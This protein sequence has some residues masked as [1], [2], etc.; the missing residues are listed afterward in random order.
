M[1]DTTCDNIQ[2]LNKKE[3]VHIYG[4]RLP[5]WF[6]ENKTVFVTFRLADSLPQEKTGRVKEDGEG[7]SNQEMDGD[8]RQKVRQAAS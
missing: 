1:T 3:F 4:K 5:H 7:N 8:N 2:F 6:Q